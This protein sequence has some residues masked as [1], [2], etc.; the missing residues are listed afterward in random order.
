[1][2]AQKATLRPTLV[3]GYLAAQPSSR[4]SWNSWQAWINQEGFIWTTA[5]GRMLSYPPFREDQM[6]MKDKDGNHGMWVGA[7]ELGRSGIFRTARILVG[8]RLVTKSLKL[9]PQ[10]IADFDFC[11]TSKKLL[12]CDGWAS[13]AVAE[14]DQIFLF[15]LSC[16]LTYGSRR[17]A[18]SRCVRAWFS[19]KHKIEDR[20]VGHVAS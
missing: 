15:A 2:R 8:F 9:P 6:R 7:H 1:M 10:D 4:E 13:G 16:F 3:V 5:I 19:P 14:R 20:Q 12:R 18:R 17:L 11:S